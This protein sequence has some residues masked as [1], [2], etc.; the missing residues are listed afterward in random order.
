MIR[1]NNDFSIRAGAFH[2]PAM[3]ATGNVG[4]FERTLRS[5]NLPTD[6]EEILDASSYLKGINEIERIAG[7]SSFFARSG[8]QQNVE[9]LGVFGRAIVSAETLWEALQ[10]TKNA[11]QYYQNNSELV[12]R[13]YRGRCRIW[14]FGPFRKRDAVQDIQYTITLLAN[15]VNLARAKVDPELSISYPA[16]SGAHF[17]NNPSVKCVRDSPQGYIEFNEDLL[18]SKMR[19]TDSMRA[20]VLSR[21]LNSENIETA[22][23]ASASEMVS[24]LVRASFG[25]APWSFSDTA[26][27]LQVGER[28]L[29]I[30]LKDEGLTFRKIVQAERHKK[31]RHLLGSGT[32]IE[33]AAEELGFEHRQSFSEA[34]SNWEGRSPSA[35]TK[36]RVP[37]RVNTSRL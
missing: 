28:T 9:D 23:R 19:R 14:Y 31:A 27:A 22:S 16:G 26:K 25:V 24:G 17:Q 11:L 15:I 1:Q 32:S 2:G 36:N 5:L 6:A 12:V 33:A 18:R 3:L 35:F 10:I 7:E 13:V 37:R 20:E 8:I 29:Q 34:F 4:R 21:F 30:R